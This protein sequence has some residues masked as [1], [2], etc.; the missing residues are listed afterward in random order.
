MTPIFFATGNANKFQEAQSI[1]GSELQ[2]IDIDLPEFQTL[3]VEEVVAEKAKAAYAQ[4]GK[5]VLVED[6]G[7]FFDAWNGFPGAL[8]KWMMKT[9]NNQGIL[10]MLAGFTNRKI[11]AVCCVGM[12]DGEK[13]IF[14][15]GS[16]EG[17]ASLTVRGDTRFAR[18]QIFIPN[19]YDKTFAEM[20]PEEKNQISMRKIAF[21]KMREQI[22]I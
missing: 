20:S 3:S 2:Q 9:V 6:T 1:L 14:A 16:I 8:I 7:L 13:L 10:D 18:D 4:T 21:E 15:I 22:N 5:S 19:G 12:Y 17:T 11:T